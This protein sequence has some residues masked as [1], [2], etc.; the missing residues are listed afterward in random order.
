MKPKSSW[1]YIGFIVIVVGLFLAT[2]L[3]GN[4]PKLGL[5]LQGGVSV[6]SGP[7]DSFDRHAADTREAGAGLCHDVVVDLCVREAPAAVSGLVDIGARFSRAALDHD[8]G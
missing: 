7:E 4:K 1:P 6:V 8:G 2:L 3:S 5:D